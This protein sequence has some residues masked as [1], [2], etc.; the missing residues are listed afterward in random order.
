LSYL[1]F[2]EQYCLKCAY[3]LLSDVIIGLFLQA[4]SFENSF[5]F[6]TILKYNRRHS[7]SFPIPGPLL[8]LLSGPAIVDGLAQADIPT[9]LFFFGEAV[10]L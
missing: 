8:L 9:R 6:G 4:N 5:K 2:L 10:E 3:D 1:L 7:S